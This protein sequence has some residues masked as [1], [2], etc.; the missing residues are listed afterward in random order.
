MEP[1]ERPIIRQPGV[2]S[3][4]TVSVATEDSLSTRADLAALLHAQ[5]LA[6]LRAQHDAVA[7]LE[8]DRAHVA[9]QRGVAAQHVDHPHA[10]AA[11]DVG[12]QR[13][14]PDQA[15]AFGHRDLGE[16]FQ[17]APVAQQHAER[18]P[19]G[20]QVAPEERHVEHRR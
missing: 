11:E 13:R 5:K 6:H 12:L 7:H 9:A 15:R 2:I 4:S 17:L 1:S 19:V 3:T 20:Q 10:V 18:L 14:L 8:L 16:V